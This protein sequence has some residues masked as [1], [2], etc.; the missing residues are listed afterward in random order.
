MFAE[1]C[2]QEFGF[3]FELFDFCAFI[4]LLVLDEGIDDVV[5]SGQRVLDLDEVGLLVPD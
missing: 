1:V 2:D 4:E 5:C 3:V